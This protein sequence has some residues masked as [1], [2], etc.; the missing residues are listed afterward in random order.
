MRPVATSFVARLKM[1]TMLCAIAFAHVAHAEAVRV[2]VVGFTVDLSAQELT[3]LAASIRGSLSRQAD[4]KTLVVVTR[5]E[6][7]LVYSQR[8]APCR[9]DDVA[10]IVDASDA[11]Q[12]RLFVRGV[13]RKAS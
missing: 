9:P 4:P 8:G 6:M 1:L 12:G 7:A 2:A 10:C 3:D 13:V 5:E 11:W